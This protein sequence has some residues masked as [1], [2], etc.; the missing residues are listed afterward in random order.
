MNALDLLTARLFDYAGMFPPASLGFAEA[1][2]EAARAPRLARPSMLA[3]D[4]VVDGANLRNVTLKA[5]EKAGFGD[6]LC[7]VALV[8]VPEKD[9][10][11]VLPRVA[12]F[13]QSR[14]GAAA[15]VSV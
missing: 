11:R 5:L 1:L 6:T 8:G 14:D 13:N 10:R 7:S 9:L 2:A 4:M 3:T 12:S 15:V